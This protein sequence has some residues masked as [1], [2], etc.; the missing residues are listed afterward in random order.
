[1][2]TT[3]MAV[4]CFPKLLRDV[5]PFSAHGTLASF[6]GLTLSPSLPAGALS[7]DYRRWEFRLHFLGTAIATR[8]H[9]LE[10]ILQTRRT[11]VPSGLLDDV[12]TPRNEVCNPRHLFDVRCPAG[13]DRFASRDFAGQLSCRAGM[14]SRRFRGFRRQPINSSQ[15]TEYP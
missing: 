13:T 2:G 8:H 11:V 9:Q 1:M 3:L 7:S 10:S 14:R 5:L 15:T 6:P 4:R 12:E